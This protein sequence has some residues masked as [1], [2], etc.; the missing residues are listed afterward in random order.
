MQ[1]LYEMML[2]FKSS[3][4]D[5]KIKKFVD[6]IGSLL[7]KEGKITESSLTGKRLFSYPIKKEKEGIYWLVKFEAATSIIE[8]IKNKLK[9]EED[10]L[11]YLIIKKADNKK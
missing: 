1:N 11:R 8:E 9:F 10:L 6:Q 3:Q 4:D 7:G 5:G 2:I